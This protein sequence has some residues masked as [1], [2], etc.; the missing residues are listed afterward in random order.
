MKKLNVFFIPLFLFL[1]SLFFN[2]QYTAAQ[3]TTISCGGV[4]GGTAAGDDLDGDGVCNDKDVDD[5][6]DGIK[7]IVESPEYFTNLI[8]DGGFTVSGEPA[9]T[10]N[11]WFV[12]VGT[13]AYGSNYNYSTPHPYT[14]SLTTFSYGANNGQVN[15][16]LTGG[17]FASIGGSNAST[18]ILNVLTEDPNTP[19]V[20]KFDQTLNST[21]NYNLEFDIA[22]R[23]NSGAP[24]EDYAVY[25]YNGTT[26][27]VEQT[28][29]QAALS[30]LHYVD[31]GPPYTGGTQGAGYRTLQ[32]SFSVNSST[33]QYYLV[34]KTLGAQ[35]PEDDFVIDRVA[36]NA[37]SVRDTDG[38][39]VP[40]HQDLD[41]DNDGIADV[42]ESGCTPPSGTTVTDCRLP[43][44]NW[45]TGCPDGRANVTCASP[46]NTDGTG[47]PDYLDLD[48]DGD[49]CSDA[50]EAGTNV[51]TVNSTG[52]TVT[53]SQVDANGRTN[54]TC[55]APANNSW[56]TYSANCAQALPVTFDNV[57]AYIQ[58]GTLQVNWA[59]VTEKN[60]DH[61]EIEISKDG[62]KWNKASNNI[63]S[64]GDGGNSD[65]AINYQQ[66][67]PLSGMAVMGVSMFLLSMGI[68]FRRNKWLG[69][70][71]M[72]VGISAVLYGCSKNDN[73][74]SATAEKVYVRIKQVD[75]DG[76]ASYSKVVTA[77]MK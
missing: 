40:D 60:N 64:K 70:V 63:I 73:D 6:N 36:M 44:P 46:V 75:K 76:T 8:K 25:L 3:C 49:G 50:A 4:L 5:D 24:N 20:Y 47:L 12:G 62:K 58:S 7:D 68:M 66:S 26:N 72:I 1:G 15:S 61:F 71:L 56:K 48:S 30:T 55:A 33:D 37:G 9:L 28:L 11:G 41:S 52:Y 19:I 45:G 54:A 27:Q 18:G 13:N 77:I 43:S 10:N 65:V 29:H 59:T 35:N 53:A 38:D 42:Y 22:L 16:P 14:P 34:F 74:I 32:M 17:I 51:Y 2:I 39:G 69:S 23:G 31:P 67:I 57:T 21:I